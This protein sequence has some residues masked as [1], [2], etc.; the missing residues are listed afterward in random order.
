MTR[1]VLAAALLFAAA[2]A[3][4]AARVVVVETSDASELAWSTGQRAVV[5]ELMAGDVDLVLRPSHARSVDALEREVVDAAREP[6]TAGA[7][8][9]AR[10]GSVGFAL[11]ALPTGRSPVR[12]EDDVGQGAVADGAVALRV[13]EVLN[14]RR[15]DLP[16]DRAPSKSAPVAES[17]PPT[18]VWPWVGV[19][20]VAARG[21]STAAP[22]LTAG[23]RVPM[24]DW[25]S[26]EPSGTFMLGALRVD[27]R[28]GDVLLSARQAALELVVAPTARR[29]LSGGVGAGAGVAWLSGVPRASAGYAGTERSTT[30]SLLAL[31]GFGV[32]QERRLRLLAFAEI[33]A[34]LPPVT[35]HATGTEVARVG[36][37]WL[38]GGL[39]LGYAL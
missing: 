15:F 7:V 14:A 25:I 6:D 28:A 19:A 29:G 8:G 33:S 24:T 18:P 10:E 17:P 27:T 30:V 36:I 37:P 16:P 4:A 38:T 35:V 23:L 39:A 22:T 2:R 20:V 9:V 32:W 12:I 26:I 21:A 31:R 11:V 5:A 13:S 34:L 1:L 3:E